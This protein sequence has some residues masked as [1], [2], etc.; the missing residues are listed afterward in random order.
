MQIISKEN[1]KRIVWVLIAVI[2]LSGCVPK[3]YSKSQ[4]EELVQTCLPAVNEFLAKG[5][6]CY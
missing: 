5:G 1:A 2:M 4:E 3:R 6:V